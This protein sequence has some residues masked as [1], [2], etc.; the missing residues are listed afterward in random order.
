MQWIAAGYKVKLPQKAFTKL[1]PKGYEMAG[2]MAGEADMQACEVKL[3]WKLSE[4]FLGKVH[5]VSGTNTAA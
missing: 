3:P 4:S 5:A 1:S 2:K